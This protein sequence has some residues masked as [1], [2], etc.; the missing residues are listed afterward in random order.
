M[1]NHFSDLT[2][3]K[4]DRARKKKSYLPH[5]EDTRSISFYY[6]TLIQTPKA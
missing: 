6:V 2:D 5:H 3:Y 4:D 1:N